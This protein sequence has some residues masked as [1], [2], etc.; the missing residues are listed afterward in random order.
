[1]IQIVPGNRAG[2]DNLAEIVDSIRDTV[3]AA[4]P[5]AQ[6]DRHSIAPEDRMRVYIR[7]ACIAHDIAGIVHSGSRGR[8]KSGRNRQLL[9]PGYAAGVPRVIF[10]NDRKD[11]ALTRNE[12]GIINR[13]CLAYHLTAQRVEL[14]EAPVAPKKSMHGGAENIPDHVAKVVDAIRVTHNAEI[15]RRRVLVLP[16]DCVAGEVLILTGADNLAEIIDPVR[17][18]V[19]FSK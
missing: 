15:D 10:P 7:R 1:M 8:E 2:P 17:H 13:A 12:A 19:D 16:K 11:I 4:R 3:V 14:N 18:D 9:N 6:V 5:H